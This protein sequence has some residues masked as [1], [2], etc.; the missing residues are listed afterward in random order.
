MCC[1][2]KAQ[3]KTTG[4]RIQ[5]WRDELKVFEGGSRDRTE[6]LYG[7]LLASGIGLSM[8]IR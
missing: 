5:K 3:I 1:G 4:M 7:E 6:M 2:F 8:K